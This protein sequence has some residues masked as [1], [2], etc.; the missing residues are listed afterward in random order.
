MKNLF[1]FGQAYGFGMEAEELEDVVETPVEDTEVEVDEDVASDSDEMNTQE[2]QEATPQIIDT[3]DVTNVV[4]D[5]GDTFEEGNDERPVTSD[6]DYV[7]E[8][9]QAEIEAIER[10]ADQHEQEGAEMGL[11]EGDDPY[12]EVPGGVDLTDDTDEKMVGVD[13]P[14]EYAKI[15]ETKVNGVSPSVDDY[16][17]EEYAEDS[18]GEDS[19]T[20]PAPNESVVETPE[21]AEPL[22]GGVDAVTELQA[23]GA[24]RETEDPEVSGDDLDGEEDENPALSAKD[25]LGTESEDIDIEEDD[26]DE[27]VEDPED[28]SEDEEEM[29]EEEI[30]EESDE[31][32]DVED[33]TDVEEV[34][35]EE[36]SEISMEDDET[37]CSEE[38]AELAKLDVELNMDSSI[39]PEEKQEEAEQAV[40]E[41]EITIPN[42]ALDEVSEM[43]TINDVADDSPAEPITTEEEGERVETATIDDETLLS[44]VVGDGV[45]EDSHGEEES[46]YEGDIPVNADTD[47][48]QQ[49]SE[50]DA[51]YD[52]GE[53][54]DMDGDEEL[55]EDVEESEDVVEE[56]AVEDTVD[57]DGD[58]VDTPEEADAV[59]EEET[60]EVED[61]EVD[62][63]EVEDEEPEE[64]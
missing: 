30:S 54:S 44:D 53:S 12:H 40:E 51:S 7:P 58:A 35:T 27:D 2:L 20:G 8:E 26:E 57:G 49:V 6:I 14:A 45:A 11:A 9:L 55:S 42:E 19:I 39:L 3:D 61:V 37:C 63:E 29:P 13:E 24:V 38:Y 28:D 59:I 23:N 18:Y 56:D 36:D 1:N 21:D 31:E 10:M 15:E 52:D 48:E 41:T 47:E 32:V 16:M 64:E 50:G 5:L 43:T 46:F 17:R 62:D 34:D 33:E 25:V 60:D 22:G 4:D